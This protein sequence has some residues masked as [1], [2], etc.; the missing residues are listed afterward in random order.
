MLVCR[1]DGRAARVSAI[2]PSI[3]KPFE[4]AP[5]N[6]ADMKPAIRVTRGTAPIPRAGRDKSSGRARSFIHAIGDARLMARRIPQN[7]TVVR[8]S[9]IGA[10]QA[11][12]RILREK[13]RKKVP[14]YFPPSIEI[15]LL[16]VAC[17]F[18][19]P[20][21]VILRRAIYLVTVCSRNTTGSCIQLDS[22]IYN[23]A[24]LCIMYVRGASSI[25]VKTPCL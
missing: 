20:A 6:S 11:R 13:G 16:T 24:Q 21:A 5:R 2:V 25:C 12:S 17:A 7:R 18:I 23:Y 14:P 1:T 8:L 3:K 10:R 22:C 4:R 15:Y 19:S 9:Q